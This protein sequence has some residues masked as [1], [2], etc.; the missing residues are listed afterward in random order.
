M[1]KDHTHLLH[2]HSEIWLLKYI[3]TCFLLISL[4]RAALYVFTPEGHVARSTNDGVTW[5]W[6]TTMLPVA[7]CVDIT[8]D[9]AHNLVIISKTGEMYR[10]V[11]QGV[12]WDSRGNI[13]VSDACA[14]WAITGLTFV[15]TESG[16]FYQ[17]EEDGTWS[18]LGNVGASDCID[19]APKPSDG[20]L[21]FTR[22]GDVWDITTDPF[23][24]SL[25]GNIGSSTV[26]GATSL[27]SSVIATTKEGDIARSVNDGADWTWVG[28]VS[29]LSIIGIANKSNN[30]YLTT[31]CGEIARSTDQGSDWT[32]QG[33]V[34]Q[35]NIKGITSDTLTLIGVTEYKGIK[36]LNIMHICP[37]PSVGRF[38][39]HFQT[40]G[41]G[42][43]HIRLF[44][45][46]GREIELLWQGYI[47]EGIHAIPL[48]TESELNG[49]FFLEIDS[50][51]IRTTSKIIIAD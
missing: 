29:Q 4:S 49:I 14:V 27:T 42:E 8:S 22:T 15:V 34:N 41:E 51:N 44:D 26:T 31:H 19:L 3:L 37:N 21:V 32:W 47:F 38:A 50:D 45:I 46:L 1:R 23:T 30:V 16:D 11:N 24:T 18:L 39:L 6:L 12:S 5:S 13:P 7:N 9:P 20:W 48:C 40:I 35:I 10:S 36:A 2:G 43:A 33:N 28:A 17:R 25:V